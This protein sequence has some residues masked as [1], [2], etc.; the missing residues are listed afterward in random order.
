MC[1]VCHSVNETIDL[2]E[3]YL[4]SDKEK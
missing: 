3:E 1:R 2:L 4:T